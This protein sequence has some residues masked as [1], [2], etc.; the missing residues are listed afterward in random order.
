MSENKMVYRLGLD[1]GSTSI[2]WAMLR[3]NAQGDPCAVIKAGVRIFSD[4]RNPKNGQSLASVRRQ[5]R[6]QRRT[7]DRTKRRK[8]RLIN[9]LVQFG[10]F[11]Q[12]PQARRKLEILNPY[13]IRRKAL[14]EK[15]TPYEFGRAIFHLAQRRGFKSNRRTDQKSSE[16]GLLKDAIKQT[17]A[18]LEKKGYRTVGEMFADRQLRRLPV[19]S[20]IR[21]VEV[22]QNG[23]TKNT[24]QYDFYLDRELIQN[25][26][27][28]IWE[29]QSSLNPTLFSDDKKERLYDTIFFQRDLRPVKPGRCTLLPDEERAPLALP[30]QQEFR[31]YQEL[32]NLKKL[33]VNLR[34]IPLSLEER[35]VLAED[36]NKSKKRTFEQMRS[37]IGYEGQF[38][39]E[40]AGR[41]ELKGNETAAILGSKKLIGSEWFKY[42][43]EKQDEIVDLL[44]TVESESD[45]INQLHQKY[46]FSCE[47][48]TRLSQVTLPSGYGSLSRKALA[49]IVPVLKSEVIVYSDAVQKAGFES[50]SSLDL[51]HQTGEVMYELPYYGEAL[52]RHVG[53]G[54]NDPSDPDE[55]RYGKIAN[56]TVHVGL[57]ELRKVVNELIRTYGKPAE[58]VVELARELK[59]SRDQKLEVQRKQNQNK[60]KNAAAT[61][62]VAEILGCNEA[63]VSRED[64]EKWLLWEEL[65]DNALDRRCP[66]TGKQISAASLFSEEIEIEHILPYS[67]TL[68]DSMSNKTVSY[69]FANRIKGNRTPWEARDIFEKNGLSYD[70]IL[71]RAEHLPTSKRFRFAEDGYEVWLRDFKDFTARM[72]TDTQYLCRIS[73]EYLELICPQKTM[74]IPGRLTS[75]LRAKYGLNR[76][77]NDTNAKNRDDHRHHAIDACVIAVTDRSLLQKIATRAAQNN[78]EGQ[79]LLQDIPLPW[80]TYRLSVQRAIERI[81]V[82]HK[83]DHSYEGQMHDATAYGIRKDGN[84]VY[85]K[86]G[87]RT[88]QKLQVIPIACAKA[89]WRHGINEDGTPRAYKGFKG[90]SNYCVEIVLNDKGAWV[91]DVISTFDAYRIVRTKGKDFLREKLSRTGKPLIMRL[92]KG[93]VLR[94]KLDDGYRNYIVQKFRSDGMVELA[95]INEANVSARV[96]ET[97]SKDTIDYLRKTVS[98]LQKLHAQRVTVSPA[99]QVRIHRLGY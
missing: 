63:L 93:D 45:L 15:L 8:N 3:L 94:L 92:L 59:M 72:L 47:L 75:M 64:I 77:L 70:D 85:R 48:A 31:I 36:L 30:S 76:I 58:I 38:N 83:P 97:D 43:L 7:Q 80:A 69:R 18:I 14:D 2:G 28:L 29:K 84:V 86:D 12:D 99:G 66:Y 37:K 71:A 24:K 74:V 26:F 10:F 49:Q 96:R 6:Q 95:G 65:G 78:E 21:Q 27:C 57:N 32:N 5:A 89:T 44:L 25:E 1:I 17:K 67:R 42:D 56:P 68:D 9:D 54:T 51:L 60:K 33:D 4:S 82:S 41:T 46:G 16:T 61:H 88:V 87:V 22:Q 11:P 81:V 35:N 55:I 34:S 19:R 39:L 23:R 40:D 50:H 53:F 62:A 90:N 52:T 98:G 79:R 13:E 91:A 73:K 20:R